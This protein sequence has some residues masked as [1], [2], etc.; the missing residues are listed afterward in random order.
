MLCSQ[1]P[2]NSSRNG[3]RKESTVCFHVKIYSA[4]YRNVIWESFELAYNYSNSVISVKI[5]VLKSVADMI[6]LLK[7]M[8]QIQDAYVFSRD[9]G[10]LNLLRTNFRHSWCKIHSSSGLLG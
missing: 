10:S 7:Y 4:S 9:Y 5:L 3:Q 1:L 2:L 6:R 8:K